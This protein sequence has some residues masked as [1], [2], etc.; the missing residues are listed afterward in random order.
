MIPVHDTREVFDAVQKAK[1]GAS[2]FA[3]NFFPVERKLQGWIT[4]A[5]MLVERHNDAV[6][7]LRKDRDFWHLYFSAAN[8]EALQWAIGS[9]AMVK[10]ERIVTDLVGNEPGIKGLI[11]VLEAVGFHPYHRLFRMARL[12][13]SS[14]TDVSLDGTTVLFAEKSDSGA[15]FDLIFRSLDRYAE[16][17]PALH[18]IE[19]AAANRQILMVKCD[20]EL[21]GLLFFETQGLTSTVR[22]WLV[23]ERFR[24]RRFGAVLMRRYF[25]IHLTVRRFILWVMT[26]NEDAIK[27]YRHYG[28]SPD[29]L[30]DHVLTNGMIRL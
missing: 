20:G 7:F 28:F 12:A 1:A 16:Q 13:H 18:E 6:L 22:Y 30:V 11:T 23:A 24:A 27:K 26:G 4:H 10:R 21:A 5:E 9:S 3:T 25:A 14:P 17:L 29:G 2:A 15:I 8:P 19:A